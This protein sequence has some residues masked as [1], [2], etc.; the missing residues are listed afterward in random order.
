[1][2]AQ[3]AQEANCLEDTEMGLG[4]WAW[5]DR[6]FWHYG[7]GY[8]DDDIAAAFNTSLAAG[9][10]FVDTAEIYGSG[11]SEILLGKFIKT[12]EKPVRVA[13]K[14][15]PIPYRLTKNSVVKALKRSLERLQLDKVDLYQL[16]WPSPVVPLDLYVEG[17]AL[18]VEAG[19]ASHVGVSNYNKDQMQKSVK[20]LASHGIK[21]ASNQVEYHLLNRQVEKNGLLQAC[22]ETGIRLIAYSPLAMGLL[23]GK[24][25]R[26]MPPPGPRT[27][28]RRR[29]EGTCASDRPYG[30]DRKRSRR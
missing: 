11:R 26:E 6:T 24:Y 25:T 12:T 23:T 14:F 8:N 22:K 18:A 15:F 7:H 30:R 16:H 21:L 10:N 20:V 19:L 28:I 13:T 3:P 29:S 4:A 17:L 1:M 9:V 5:G 27:E 2:S